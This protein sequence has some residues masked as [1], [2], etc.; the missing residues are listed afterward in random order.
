MEAADEQGNTRKVYEGARALAGK[1]KG[2]QATQPTK[3]KKGDI[4]SSSEELGELWQ[5]FLAGKFSATELE[6]SRQGY[7]KLAETKQKDSLT[8]EEFEKA[9]ELESSEE[10]E[11]YRKDQFDE[12][13]KK[14]IEEKFQIAQTAERAN[15]RR[16]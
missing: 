16:W 6:A 12:R 8:Y 11:E 2:F 10:R 13:I 1:S 5:E 3:N 4:I 15:G 9:A 14:M 7:E